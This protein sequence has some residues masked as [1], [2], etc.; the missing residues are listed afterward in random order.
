MTGIASL[1]SEVKTNS[2]FSPSGSSS[3]VV[4]DAQDVFVGLRRLADEPAEL[5]WA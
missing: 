1:V 3:P 5:I 4:D 2:P